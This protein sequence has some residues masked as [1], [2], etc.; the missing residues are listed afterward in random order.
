[1]TKA[2]TN[3]ANVRREGN[4]KK[5]KAGARK[6]RIMPLTIGFHKTAGRHGTVW[7]D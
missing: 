3:G 6:A 7:V 2:A 4:K 1:V 5:K